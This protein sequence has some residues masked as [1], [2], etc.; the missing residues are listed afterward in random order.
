MVIYVIIGIGIVGI[1]LF[2]ILRKK[3]VKNISRMEVL[4]TGS[5]MITIER[6]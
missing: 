4:P 3:S 5:Q 6:K 2:F 1:S